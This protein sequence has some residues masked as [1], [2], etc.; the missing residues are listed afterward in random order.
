MKLKLIS[1]CLAKVIKAAFRWMLICAVAVLAFSVLA[2]AVSAYMAKRVC[3][4]HVLPYADTYYWGTRFTPCLGHYYTWRKLPGFQPGWIISYADK[5]GYS[6]RSF[7]LN[8]RADLMGEVQPAVVPAL[9]RIAEEMRPKEAR[10]AEFA[11]QYLSIQPGAEYSNIVATF[12]TP[13]RVSTNDNIV[14]VDYRIALWDL[15]TGDP[16]TEEFAVFLTNGV[17]WTRSAG[18]SSK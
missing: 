6:S 18:R 16:S 8:L 15:A 5:K 12:G 14:R 7:L 3:D 9:I 11:H 4:G 2:A 13:Y 10:V 17:V 1:D